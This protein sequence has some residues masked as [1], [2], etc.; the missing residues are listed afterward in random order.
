M[1]M[2]P[3]LKSLQMFAQWLSKYVNIIGQ[4]LKT[5]THEKK[6]QRNHDRTRV[7]SDKH[8]NICMSLVSGWA[9]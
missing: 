3:E 9:R 4:N 6:N 7:Y 1:Q 5:L 2:E 8:L